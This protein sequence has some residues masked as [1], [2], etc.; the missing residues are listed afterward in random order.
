MQ[1][2]NELKIQ[3]LETMLSSLQNTMKVIRGALK[4]AE[5][6]NNEYTS[7]WVSEQL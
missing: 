3:N 5:D 1:Q 4:H 7:R 2:E 6:Q